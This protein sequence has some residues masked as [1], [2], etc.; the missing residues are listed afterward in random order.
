MRLAGRCRSSSRRYATFAAAFA[1]PWSLA[2]GVAATTGC[3]AIL[4]IQSPIADAAAPVD[5]AGFASDA[6]PAGDSTTPGPSST[7][8]GS[9]GAGSGADGTPAVLGC[10]G[11]QLDCE[12]GCFD[13]TDVL[14]CGSC[15]NDCTQLPNVSASQ[16][17]C[18]AGRCQYA[19]A[20]GFADCADAGTGCT[21]YLGTSSNCGGCGTA[22][23]EGGA[24]YCAPGDS[25]AAYAC[26][27]TCPA[28]APSL[29]TGSCI[30]EQTN[31][32]NCGGCGIA[33]TGSQVCQAGSCTCVPCT[34]DQSLL[35]QCC[36]Q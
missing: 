10:A 24:P 26:V 18:V 30:D 29:C 21:T 23:T 20:A 31:R 22:C 35:D 14:H 5:V 33:C 4:G 8:S 27:S 34:L 32:G 2:I 7:D 9:I 1:V 17:A 15:S 11:D 25:G 12:G 3:Q 16:L 36:L 19:C 6:S 28:S 13:P